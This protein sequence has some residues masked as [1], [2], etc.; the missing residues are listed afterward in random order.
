LSPPVLLLLKAVTGSVSESLTIEH[1]R[2]AN[3][4]PCH[5]AFEQ[6]IPPLAHAGVGKLH[7]PMVLDITGIIVAH[8]TL[9]GKAVIVVLDIRHKVPCTAGIKKPVSTIQKIMLH[10]AA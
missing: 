7:A 9:T 4:G 1:F 3:G 10:S 5:C 6:D 8:A 2:I